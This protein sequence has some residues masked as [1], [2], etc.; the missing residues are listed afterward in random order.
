MPYNPEIAN[1][2]SK[3]LI[4]NHVAQLFSS[5]LKN[6]EGEVKTVTLPSCNWQLEMFMA[7]L[8][9]MTQRGGEMV[10]REKTPYGQIPSQIAMKLSSASAKCSGDL[11]SKW[12][13]FVFNS[14]F[15]LDST[16]IVDFIRDNIFSAAT[17]PLSISYDY[18]VSGSFSFDKDERPTFYYA[19]LCGFLPEEL[20]GQLENCKKGDLIVF[21]VNS[22]SR[23]GYWLD[24]EECETPQDRLRRQVEAVRERLEALDLCPKMVYLSEYENGGQNASKLATFA[25]ALGCRV[26]SIKGISVIQSRVPNKSANGGKGNKFSDETLKV[27]V[28]LSDEVLRALPGL[29]IKDDPYGYKLAGLKAARTR[30]V[31]RVDKLSNF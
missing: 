13:S 23:T 26:K 19:D 12:Q 2:E 24:M 8:L 14:E 15:G 18:G 28:G 5:W 27:L 3:K 17:R 31:N 1:A 25:F 7:N 4:R 10:C 16:H 20:V 11:E 30:Y 29:G 9:T 6:N 22:V 21:T